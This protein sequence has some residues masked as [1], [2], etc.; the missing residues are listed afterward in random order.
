MLCAVGV[1]AA[2]ARPTAKTHARPIAKTE[3]LVEALSSSRV[4]VRREAATLLLESGDV[5]LLPELSAALERRGADKESID[6]NDELAAFVLAGA[7]TILSP[8]SS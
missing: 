3:R 2:E 7:S 8:P 4:E 1:I 5:A 6:A